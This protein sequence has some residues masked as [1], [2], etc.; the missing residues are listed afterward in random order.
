M[1]DFFIFPRSIASALPNPLSCNA[2]VTRLKI[3]PCYNFI[4]GAL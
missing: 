1:A 4:Q 3:S 2:C